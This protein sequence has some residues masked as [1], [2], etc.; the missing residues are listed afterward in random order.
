MD[1][2]NSVIKAQDPQMVGAIP[3][4]DALLLIDRLGVYGSAIV[5]ERDAQ[6]LCRL[7]LIRREGD[8][9]F[10]LSGGGSVDLAQRWVLSERG[11]QL[12]S[13]S[14]VDQQRLINVFEKFDAATLAR[15]EKR[16]SEQMDEITAAA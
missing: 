4:C 16:A 3:Q 9:I 7:D 13:M 15:A 12:F 6:S 10:N 2:K 5:S 11:R 14:F 1:E 8:P